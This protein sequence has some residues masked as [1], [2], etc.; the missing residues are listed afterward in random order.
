[1]PARKSRS[2]EQKKSQLSKMAVLLD[3]IA[4]SGQGHRLLDRLLK[5]NDQ[6]AAIAHEIAKSSAFGKLYKL[7]R[8]IDIMPVWQKEADPD[9]VGIAELDPQLPFNV[10]F[11]RF[12]RPRLA[13]RADGFAAIFKALAS[14][15][16]PPLIIE[17]GCLRIPGNWEGDGQSS[18]MFDALVRDRHGVFLSIDITPECIDTARRACSSATQLICN[19][20]ISALHALSQIVHKPASLL[21]LDSFDL[22]RSNPMPS[23]IHHLMELT[24]ARPLIGPGTIIC[25]DDYQVGEQRGGKGLLLDKFFSEIRADVLHSGYQKAWRFT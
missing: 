7:S 11:E 4:G 13:R 15:Q 2:F 5:T 9:F 12:F 6:A 14:Q 22:D 17:T 25:V 23:A 19:D 8:T 21:Y 10:Q 20:S 16:Q 3:Q 18:F 24:A 1:M